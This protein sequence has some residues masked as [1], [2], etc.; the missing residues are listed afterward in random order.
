MIK[1]KFILF[2]LRKIS[3]LNINDNFSFN[4]FLDN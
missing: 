3:K 1:A 2:Q 4:Y